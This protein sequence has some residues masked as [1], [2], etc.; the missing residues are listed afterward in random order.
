MRGNLAAQYTEKAGGERRVLERSRCGIAVATGDGTMRVLTTTGPIHFKRDGGWREINPSLVEGPG[1]WRTVS[2]EYGLTVDP[3]GGRRFTPRGDV[4]GERVDL[5][6]AERADGSP[7]VS[8]QGVREG[9]RVELRAPH[10]R[11]HKPAHTVR[12]FGHNVGVKAEVEFE[13]DA[14]P[15]RWPVSFRGLALDGNVLRAASGEPVAFMRE[16][17][18][19]DAN[20]VR[21]VVEWRYED[22]YLYYEPQGLAGASYPVLLDP[23]Y[24]VPTGADD[25]YRTSQ[26]SFNTA[27]ANL[28]IGHHTSGGLYYSIW[29]R[30]SGV[31]VVNAATISAADI[32]FHASATDSTDTV[33]SDWY[34]IDEDDHTAPTDD[35]AWQTDHGIHTT[36][37][38]AWDFTTDWTANSY[39]SSPELKTILQELV[40]RPGWAT[41]QAMGFHLDDGTSSADAHRHGASFDHATN[42]PPLLDFTAAIAAQD[43]TAPYVDAT[44]TFHTFMVSP[45]VH[46]P[47][48]EPL[49]IH[50]PSVGPGVTVPLVEPLDIHAPQV[51]AGVEV[52]LV[53]PLTI[54]APKVN[55]DTDVPFVEPLTIHDFN[56]G[57]EV[58]VPLVEPLTIHA[59]GNVFASAL[60]MR[61]KARVNVLTP[62]PVI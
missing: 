36:A 57:P 32:E 12:V 10:S 62:R 23:S 25:G 8:G 29:L 19:V 1:G 58:T 30:F 11:G 33:Y 15:V 56:I 59:L 49:T 3:G 52:P 50:A 60:P 47:L 27:S 40:D 54:H 4:E 21:G 7:L 41:G 22:G 61:N 35:T 9:N 13:R 17:F 20:G 6:A 43:L 46:P 53:E 44:P 39:Y 24:Y 51:D 38:V 37:T 42:D 45:T 2:T 48:V 26:P 5:G 55:L 28:V 14:G 31:A 18:W 16:P 34:G